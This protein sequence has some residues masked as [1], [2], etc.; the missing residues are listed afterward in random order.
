ME[1]LVYPAI[2]VVWKWRF[3]MGRGTVVP[4]PEPLRGGE[5]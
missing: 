4:T 5:V 2:Y 3:E 1:L